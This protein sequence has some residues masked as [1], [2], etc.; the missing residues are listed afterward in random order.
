MRVLCWGCVGAWGPSYK[1][2]S[3]RRN[4]A[5]GRWLRNECPLCIVIDGINDQ[6]NVVVLE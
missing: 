5:V 6:G 1:Y 3:G 4:E 2:M